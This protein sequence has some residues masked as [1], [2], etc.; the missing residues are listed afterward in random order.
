MLYKRGPAPRYTLQDMR[1]GERRVSANRLN[2]VDGELL[3][4][5]GSSR[6]SLP[7]L[8]QEHP[9]PDQGRR[10]PDAAAALPR[11]WPGTSPA[12]LMPSAWT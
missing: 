12:P 6:R 7:D 4:R 1:D 5:A 11:W 10:R 3:N 9:L 8:Q 2:G